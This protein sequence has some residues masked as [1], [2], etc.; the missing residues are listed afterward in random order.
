LYKKE[1]EI[2][3]SEKI[4]PPFSDLKISFPLGFFK[5]YLYFSNENSS[6]IQVRETLLLWDFSSI[7]FISA[8]VL[9]SWFRF[10]LFFLFLEY[11][12]DYFFLV[13]SLFL[14]IEMA[15][16]EFPKGTTPLSKVSKLGFFSISDKG[17]RGKSSFSPKSWLYE[18]S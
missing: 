9:S 12:Y 15:S 17:T 13:L 14:F 3:E 8:C 1:F 7:T 10:L 16:L 4:F 2:I 6:R 11:L 18:Y 5:A